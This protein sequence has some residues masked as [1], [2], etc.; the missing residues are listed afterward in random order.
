MAEGAPATLDLFL[1]GSR[2]YVQGT[3]IIARLAERLP[4][5]AWRLDQANFHAITL[6]TLAFA[7]AGAAD[8]AKACGRVSFS[9]AEQPS[10]TFVLFETEREAPRRD[11][12][13]PITVTRQ[14][15]EGARAA[16]AYAGVT[17][18]EDALNVLVQAIKAENAQRWP[19]GED[20]W[21]T[22]AR[23]LGLPVSAPPA[24]S[25]V[26]NLTLYRQIGLSGQVQTIWHSDFPGLDGAGMITFT[27]KLP[28]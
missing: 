13:M 10:V 22:G 17:S 27:L 11:T 14:G 3:Q 20:I 24:P 12:A 25:G 18:F 9:S 8:E 4:P 16:W 7:R 2:N 5:G 19:K 21:F 6:R 28:G 1:R 23:R 15:D 26:L